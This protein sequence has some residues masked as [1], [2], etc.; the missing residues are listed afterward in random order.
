MSEELYKLDSD[1]SEVLRLI[2]KTM[3]KADDLYNKYN[4]YVEEYGK[5]KKDI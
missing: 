5:N 4:K 3:V 2:N 1:F